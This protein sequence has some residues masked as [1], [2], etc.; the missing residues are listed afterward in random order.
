MKFVPDPRTFA[1]EGDNR[2]V[3][4]AERAA[5]RVSALQ[6]GDATKTLLAAV[7]R[8]LASGA[9][10]EIRRALIEATSAPCLAAL[11]RA[12][13]AALE[14]PQDAP[15][16]VR[17]FAVPLVIV[18]GGKA[19]GRI[20]GVV[21]DTAVLRK[22]FDVH[23]A[24][25]RAKNFGLGTALV[26]AESI[27]GFSPGLL[28]RL[29]RAGSQP[30][31]AQLDFAPVDIPLTSAEEQAHLRF[32]AGAVVT[33]RNAPDFTETAGNIGAWGMPFTRE[34]AGQLGQPGLSLLP[35]PRPPM[36]FHRA[37]QAGRFAWREIGFQL[38]LSGALRTFRS[39]IGDPEVTVASIADGSVRVRLE[40]RLDET[41]KAEFSWPLEPEDDLAAVSGSIFGLLE[42]C[43]LD[44]VRI[45]ETVL[46]VSA[47]HPH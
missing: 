8:A 7:E 37:L 20:P 42:E 34:L 31:A 6:Q 25:G 29:S 18:T 23:G 38:F 3:A 2:L 4:L 24:L 43:R 16:A 47:S 21:P 26:T 22:L 40:S 11:Y 15:L 33:P 10:G 36:N 12:I 28:Y 46:P 1:E 32:L 41:P 30:E 19:S 44:N 39:R 9:D 5:N 45:A 27:S 17:L 35:I 13:G 14:P